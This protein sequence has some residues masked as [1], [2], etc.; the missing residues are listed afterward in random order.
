MSYNLLR[1]EKI[2]K[3]SERLVCRRERDDLEHLLL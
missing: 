2:L 3:E 1:L